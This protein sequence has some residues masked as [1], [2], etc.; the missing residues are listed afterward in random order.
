MKD[1]PLIPRAPSE[2][3]RRE[4]AVLLLQLVSVDEEGKLAKGFSVEEVAGMLSL[5]LCRVCKKNIAK[6]EARTCGDPSCVKVRCLPKR[7]F[8]CNRCGAGTPVYK[9]S[10]LGQDKD[11]CEKC[12][13]LELSPRRV[14]AKKIPKRGVCTNCGGGYYPSTSRGRK[15]CA[16]C[17]KAGV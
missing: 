17:R 4:A 12:G 15:V 1:H 9:R 3:R 2:P 14:P 5:R 11:F 16:K 10:W 8:S 7:V 6:Y 13:K